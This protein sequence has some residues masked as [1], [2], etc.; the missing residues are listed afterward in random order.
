MP[1]ANSNEGSVDRQPNVILIMT[2][3]QGFGDLNCHGN[4]IIETPH[5][6]ELHAESGRLTDF[7][8]SPTC[9]PTRAA[10]MTG[11][12]DNRTG[13]WHT[14][15]GRS[16]LNR[17]EVTM[18]DVFSGS[19]YRTGIFGKWH[20]GDNY[21]YRPQDRGF[22]DV[23]IHG[24]GGVAQTPDYWSND[25]FDDTYFQDNGIPAS[26]DGY[27]TDVW[28]DNAI[29]FI[30]ANSGH[31]T[32]FFC[33]IPTNAPH[34]PRQ[35]PEEY[36][37]EY[38]DEVPEDVARFYGMITNIDDNIG[39]LRNRLYDLGVSDNTILI[40]LSDNGTACPYY[41]AGMRAQKGS[42]YEGGH[43]VPCFI[44]WPG[45]IEDI[46]L[47][48]LSAHYDLL[49]T[50][51]DLCGLDAPDI[52]FDGQSLQSLLLDGESVDCD[53]TLF[54]DSQR[55]EWPEKWKDSAVMTDQWRLV[56]GEEL[57]DI[58]AD[59][60]QE[61]DL[62][63]DHPEIIE[64]LR[65][66]YEEWWRDIGPFETYS[67]IEIGAIEDSVD[68]TCHDWHECENVPWHQGYILQGPETNGFWAIEIAESRE[69]EISLRR[70]PSESDTPINEIPSDFNEMNYGTAGSGWTAQAQAINPDTARIQIGK[71]ERTKPVQDGATAVT[72]SETLQSGPTRLQTWFEGDYIERGAYF[73]SI[74]PV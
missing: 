21:P 41:N 11:R 65:A 34:G 42:P 51:I 45:V 26:F 73:V 14:I 72:F 67:R 19:G 16:L 37:E 54:I 17:T 4:P 40:F 20:L 2:D 66:E 13:V 7:H 59:P 30:E 6:D 29:S 61:T 71:T 68:L 64:E 24:G 46:T 27:C 47:D 3:D 25:Y 53:R 44:R 10:L 74:T 36:L 48:T 43:R 33:Y 60:G 50:L 63:D 12:Y 39:R 9:A 15:L 49:P 57:Y 58:N 22:D 31:Q 55:T 8:V 52:D 23:L 69:Y 62:A 32:P 35:V 56:R 38:I 70:W 1:I 18:A 28:F 5:L